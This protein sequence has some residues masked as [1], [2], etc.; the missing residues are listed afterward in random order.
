MRT[1]AFGLHGLGIRLM[2]FSASIKTWLQN[3]AL[4]SILLLAFIQGLLC[5][6]LIPPWW[7]YDEPGHFE[8][9]WLAAHSPTWPVAGQYDQA[10][11]REL[12]VSLQRY[13]WY[14]IRNTKPDLNSSEPIPI[15][16]PQV[17]DQPGYYFL[18]AL[19]LR[20]I[21]NADVTTQDSVVRAFSF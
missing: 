19:P 17:G 15:G 20:L 6:A 1:A 18:A 7:H 16:V 13:G 12:A 10:M 9:V 21:P 14:S 5:V 4:L 8:Y 3:R 2:H 11:R